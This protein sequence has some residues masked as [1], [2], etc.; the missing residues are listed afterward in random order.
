M[1]AGN[2]TYQAT[3]SDY[4]CPCDLLKFCTCTCFFF[5]ATPRN[6]SCFI[7][8][9]LYL[10]FPQILDLIRIAF[11]CTMYYLKPQFCI[12]K[13]GCTG[14]ILFVLLCY[15]YYTLY[16]FCII[17]HLYLFSSI[18]ASVFPLKFHTCFLSLYSSFCF[19]VK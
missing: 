18:A 14:A 3:V 2:P 8:K 12:A 5:H 1:Q 4:L 10:F 11:P 16:L 9:I 17:L 13:L 15:L 19:R 7:S 6:L